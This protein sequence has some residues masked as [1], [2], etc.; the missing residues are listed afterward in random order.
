MKILMIAE[1]PHDLDDIKGGAEAATVNL[2]NGFKNMQDE[3]HILSIYPNLSKKETI[4]ISDRIFIHY[5]PF[6]FKKFKLAEFFIFGNIK[7]KRLIKELKPDI[8]H[9]QGTGPMLLFLT[10]LRKDNLVITQHGIMSEELKYKISLKRKFKFMIKSLYD[11]LLIPKYYNY[12]S[13]SEYNKSILATYNLK[14]R[15]FFT[16]TI[17]NAVNDEFFKVPP[18]THSNRI[19]FVGLVNKLKGVH[20]L[21]DAIWKLKQQGIIYYLDIVGGTKEPEYN[22]QIKSSIETLQLQEQVIM[23]GWVNQQGVKDN[24]EKSS[25]FVLPS[26]QECLPISIAEAMAAG[27]VVVATRTGGIP[28]MFEDKKSGFLFEKGNSDELAEILKGLFSNDD[29]ITRISNEAREIAKQK[30]KFESV[31]QKT[32]E[33]YKDVLKKADNR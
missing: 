26:L 13:I 20:L 17:Y 7:I 1:C 3:V 8:L 21:V 22:E 18:P 24:I 16:R 33:F 23:H 31:A 30:F 5:S 29:K 9:L 14:N 27:R 32:L 19:V 4:Q 12:I 10:G 25:I 2:I 6:T 15:F 11:K 28:E